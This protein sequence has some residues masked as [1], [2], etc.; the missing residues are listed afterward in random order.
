[1]R[2]NG[3][4]VEFPEG[5]T[6]TRSRDA[7]VAR[8]GAGLVSVT[9]F[10]LL[11]AYDPTRFAAAAKELDAVAARLAKEA[12][13]SLSASG[14]V[15]VDGQKIRSYSYADERIGFFLS[16]KRE[17]QLFCKR[18]AGACDLLYRTFTLSGPQA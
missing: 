6:V 18:A 14:T 13:A 5:W 9:T 4:T 12:G 15:T 16:G 17:Y 8:R 11:K 1:V 7:V 2:G 10:P 3:F